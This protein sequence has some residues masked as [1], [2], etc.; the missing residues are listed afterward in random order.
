MA[1]RRT[2]R[3]APAQHASP[4]L[5]AEPDGGLPERAAS[6]DLDG[7]AAPDS[8]ATPLAVQVHDSNTPPFVEAEVHV[9]LAGPGAQTHTAASQLQPPL[10]LLP[11]PSDPPTR[12]DAVL[13]CGSFE[14]GTVVVGRVAELDIAAQSALLEIQGLDRFWPVAFRRIYEGTWTH[15]PSDYPPPGADMAFDERFRPAPPGAAA[16]VVPHVAPETKPAGLPTPPRPPRR[17]HVWALATV[18]LA[19]PGFS[20]EG[21]ERRDW[22]PGQWGEFP[23]RSVDGVALR[24]I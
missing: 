9:E 14:G 22:A 19:C 17:G 20:S 11:L 1:R 6:E 2:N 18:Y 16:E 8:A 15:V 13:R 10:D 7:G 5:G 12:V 23:A 3:P 24:R 21:Y 4:A